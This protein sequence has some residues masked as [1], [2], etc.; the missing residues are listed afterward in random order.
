MA[1]APSP[2]SGLPDIYAM[3]ASQLPDVMQAYSK[4]MND[5]QNQMGALQD[6]IK[7]QQNDQLNIPA[8]QFAAGLLKP[9]RTGS[10]G[11]S[12]GAGAEGA[13]SALQKQRE[14]D[15]DRQAK[16]MEIQQGKS[17]LLGDQISTLG[18]MYQTKQIQD[19]LARLHGQGPSNGQP[20]GGARGSSGDGGESE[21]DW[22][23]IGEMGAA[24]KNPEL[25]SFYATHE[26][27]GAGPAGARESAQSL[28]KPYKWTGPDGTE[29]SG[30]FGDYLKSTGKLPPIPNAPLVKSFAPPAAPSSG[31]PAAPVTAAATATAATAPAGVAAP[32]GPVMDPDTAQ[33]HSYVPPAPPGGGFPPIPR[34]ATG[35]PPGYEDQA[36]DAAKVPAEWAKQSGELDVMKNRLRELNYLG[37]LTESNQWASSKA[38]ISG[39]LK[40]LALAYDPTYDV[41]KMDA[42]KWGKPAE[43]QQTIKDVTQLAMAAA[44]AQ[45]ARGTNMVLQESLL[46]TPMA[47][48]QPVARW[49][50]INHNVAAIDRSQ[51]MMSDW[52]EAQKQ[53]WKDPNVFQQQ[54]IKANPIDKWVQSASEK[55][56]NF[57]GMPLPPKLHVGAVYVAPK[58]SK[59][60][61]ELGVWNGQSFDAPDPGDMTGLGPK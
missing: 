45:S 28:A 12:V 25:S 52:Q 9:T 10:F 13:L 60:A 58:G 39:H 1:D 35:L 30:T 50:L 8:L 57:A 31:A 55:A 43:T 6:Y 19:A 56:G 22:Q 18:P 41:S 46:T 2:T 61:G 17:K 40:G 59:H 21:G 38:E 23:T 15:L 16:I 42:D 11:E 4:S 44:R 37:K 47:D 20:V 26:R 7:N 5:T 3:A 48:M 49:N 51:Q 36:A 27:F 29:I 33:V 24:Y 53:G 32:K 54:W 14:I 34:G